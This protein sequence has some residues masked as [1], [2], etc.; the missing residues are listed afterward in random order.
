MAQATKSESELQ[1]TLDDKAGIDM[2]ALTLPAQKEGIC[3]K[4]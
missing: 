3:K 2:S 4:V 1:R